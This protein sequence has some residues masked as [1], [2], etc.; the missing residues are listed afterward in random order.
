MNEGPKRLEA[1]KAVGQVVER[2]DIYHIDTSMTPK[3]GLKGTLG[4]LGGAQR[5]PKRSQKRP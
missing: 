1:E 4:G 5:E 2:P 3:E